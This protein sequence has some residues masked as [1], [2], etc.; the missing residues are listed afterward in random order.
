[1]LN[2]NWIIFKW[3]EQKFEQKQKKSRRICVQPKAFF[4]N[5][6]HLYA[7]SGELIHLKVALCTHALKH[8]L[9]NPSFTLLN[10][11][12]ITGISSAYTLKLIKRKMQYLPVCVE[13][14]VIES[15][16]IPSHSQSWR[17]KL[18]WSHDFDMLYLA[19]ETCTFIPRMIRS[20]KLCL[21]INKVVRL[22]FW[23]ECNRNPCRCTTRVSIYVRCMMERPFTLFLY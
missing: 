2:E 22:S 5:W 23:Q 4:P 20:R 13:R 7:L 19:G 17:K 14:I 1:M 21:F 12:C 10:P 9:Q 18:Q 3:I 15:A 16:H 11:L 6:F 8:N